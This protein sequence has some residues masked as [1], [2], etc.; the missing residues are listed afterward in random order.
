M[1]GEMPSLN[2]PSNA[3]PEVNYNFNVTERD[4]FLQT[5]MIKYGLGGSYVTDIVK[6]RDVPRQPTP[7]DPVDYLEMPLRAVKKRY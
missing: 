7:D 6:D 4:V 3:D 2:E 5:M 1:I